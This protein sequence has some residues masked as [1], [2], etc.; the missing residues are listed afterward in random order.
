MSTHMASITFRNGD[1]RFGTSLARGDFD[2]DGFSDLVIGGFN[3]S[4]NGVRPGA[5]WVVRGSQLQRFSTTYALSKS[6]I[7]RN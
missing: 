3:A 5:V 4:F 2:N 6:N 1:A 7:Q